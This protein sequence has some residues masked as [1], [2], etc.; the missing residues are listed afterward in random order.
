MPVAGTDAAIKG[1]QCTLMHIRGV[2][3]ML[4]S[5]GND[6][7]GMI[8]NG[9]G[10][11]SKDLEL[12]VTTI[13]QRLDRVEKFLQSIPSEVLSGSGTGSGEKGEKGDKGP[14]GDKGDEGEPGPQGPQGPRGKGASKLTDL[15]DVNL[16]G[17]DDGAILM[18]SA[19]DG[20]WIVSF[21]E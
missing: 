13:L 5:K 6:L 14:K 7:L 1:E 15:S 11:G 10:S 2:K 16:D 3:S 4:D 17:L 12:V 9:S 21:E 8:L 18:W 19:K 20:K